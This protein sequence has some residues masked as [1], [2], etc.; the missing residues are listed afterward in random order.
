MGRGV[1]L[2]AIALVIG[3][4]LLNAVD[5]QP[6]GTDLAAS[7]GGQSEGSGDEAAATTT[8][9][10]T[11]TTVAARPPAEVKVIVANASD[12]KGAAG[13]ANDQLKAAGYNGLSPTNA[14]KVAESSVYFTAGYD[15]EAAAIAATLG[16]P[17]T[18][19][20]PLPTPPP[21]DPKTANVVVVLGADHAARFAA[22]A[23]TT[24]APTTATTA[25]A[26]TASTTTTTG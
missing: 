18:S 13:T 15:K 7:S 3:I 6:P 24:T 20:K 12:V 1:L 5:D 16:L 19:I 11:T 21:V 14:A 23:A 17:A 22:P 8:T 4:V 2:L 9:V 10:P 25:K 26:T